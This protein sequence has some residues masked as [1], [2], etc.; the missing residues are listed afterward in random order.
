MGNS[1]INLSMDMSALTIGNGA[2]KSISK[3]DR[4]EYSTE[5]GMILPD[6]YSDLPIGSHQIDHNGK[7]VTIIIKEVTSKATDPV[8]SA[9][10]NLNVGASGS[11]FDTIPFEAF[12]VN[13]G[14]YPATLATIKFDERIADWIDDS[15]PTGKK[16]I[17]YERLQVTGS[18]NNE[19]KIE[20]ILVLNKLFS[21]LASKDFK[22]L[23]Y[24]DITVFTE[25]YKG[26]YNNI[27]FHQ[28]HALSGKDAYKTA[29]YDYVLPESKR[30]EI[31]KA[32][33]NFYHSYL[34][35]AIETEDDLKEVVQNAI[36]SVLKF[37]IE[38]RRW[39]E[40]FWDGEKKISHLGNDIVVPRTPKGEVKIQPTLHV[41]L[42]MALTPLGIQVIRESDEGIGSLDFRF[43]FTNS[44]RMPLTV[45]IEFKVAHH[46]QVKKGL[47]KQLPAYLDSIRSKSGLFV[48][49][50]FKDGKFFKKPSS[51]ECGAMESWLQKEADLVSAEK[52]MNISSIILDAS[53]K[54]SASNL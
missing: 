9:A 52:N 1:G 19:E 31:P 47:T 4:S 41:I 18:P 22:N 11:G 26:R 14:K 10:A 39:I 15:E 33:N 43:L 21:T 46:Q 44:K 16:R 53:I 49:M 42:D 27:L 54:V 13:K 17:D 37:N 24:D 8:F 12:T 6:L 30:S 32:I 3:G 35:R 28:V 34:D 50:W 45:G 2:V 25:V 48:I 29:I 20:A 7:T 23:S 40:P 51:R 38:K 5:I 36:T